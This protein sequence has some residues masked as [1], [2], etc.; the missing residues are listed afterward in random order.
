[1]TTGLINLTAPITTSVFPNPSTLTFPNNHGFT[2]GKIVRTSTAVGGLLS[3][4]NYFVRVIDD[5]TISLHNTLND[6]L[7]NTAPRSFTAPVTSV[8]TPMFDSWCADSDRTI[9]N[10]FNPIADIFSTQTSALPDTSLDF[11]EA[12]VPENG[13]ATRNV[14]LVPASTNTTTDQVTY[15]TAHNL[16]TGE[17]VRVTASSN[18]LL[19]GVTYFARSITSTTVAFY[20]SAANAQAGTAVGRIDLTGP[21]AASST[22]F[23]SEWIDLVSNTN[24]TT[25]TKVRFTTAGGGVATATTYFLRA[26]DAN[27]FSLHTS[28]SDALAGTS[29]VPLTG[30]LPADS[31]MYVYETLVEHP[32]N[33]D[34]I[35]WL[36]NQS[37]QTQPAPPQALASTDVA[38]ETVTFA[39]NHGLTT[40]SPVQVTASG[41]GLTAG[42]QYFARVVNN[43]TI[44]FYDTAANA[45]AGGTTGLIN[46]T[47]PISAGVFSLYT[48]A[49]IQRSIW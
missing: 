3:G 25:G 48:Y 40:G 24:W 45:S 47:A 1:G 26:I 36:L 29:P 30:P 9:L 2:T 43:T 16:T 37:F 27:T 20:N 28:R 34:V 33:L 49:D 42:V 5:R 7:S 8:I 18:G 44:N 41:G 19:A 13:T 38:A 32:E 39:A 15:T 17:P 22:L 23:R 21:I 31:R 46:L 11:K 10:G 14:A 6:A 35:N 12:S 4:T